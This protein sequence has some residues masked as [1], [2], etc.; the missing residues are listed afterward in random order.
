[1]PDWGGLAA[2]VAAVVAI[3]ALERARRADY[4]LALYT[5]RLSAVRE[6]AE[7][8]ADHDQW[9][10]S[11]ADREPD[12][13]EV[14]K[15]LNAFRRRV[16]RWMPVLDPDVVQAVGVHMRH[17]AD[18]VR[19][20]WDDHAAASHRTQVVMALRAMI[21]TK[22]LHAELEG[23][24]NPQRLSLRRRQKPP[25]GVG[26]PAFLPSATIA[27]LDPWER[28]LLIDGAYEEQ[29]LK[30]EGRGSVTGPGYVPPTPAQILDNAKQWGR[31]A[32]TPQEFAQAMQVAQDAANA[33]VDE[34]IQSQPDAPTS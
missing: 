2:I 14:R 1:M 32:K 28:D 9:L 21:K 8:L 7:A 25:P 6:I 19:T 12:A 20:A 18:L 26:S 15:Q 34:M 30:R 5:E 16:D 23:L 4:R 22:A 13:E 11:V 33:A 17:M 29:I 24:L 3:L 27:A 10:E 31:R